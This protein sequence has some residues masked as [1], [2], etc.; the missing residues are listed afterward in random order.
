MRISSFAENTRRVVQVI[1]FTLTQA[2]SRLSTKMPR[3]GIFSV[4]SS[5]N[6]NSSK[7]FTK[8]YR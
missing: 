6:G 7:F 1:R 8:Q 3:L 2:N 4:L 5:V